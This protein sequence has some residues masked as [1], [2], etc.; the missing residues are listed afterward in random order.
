MLR[1]ERD[2]LPLIDVV[3]LPEAPVRQRTGAA[4]VEA[5]VDEQDENS[6][7]EDNEENQHHAEGDKSKE[8]VGLSRAQPISEAQPAASNDDTEDEPHFSLH[9]QH[10]LRLTRPY[11]SLSAPSTEWRC[12]VCARDEES[13]PDKQCWHC[14]RCSYDVCQQC[15]R[16]ASGAQNQGDEQA[17][18][19]NTHSNAAG[20]LQP[21]KDSTDDGESDDDEDI[22]LV[23]AKE[24][25][26]SAKYAWLP[27]DF[28]VGD[29]GTVR[30][31]SY[32]NNLHPVQHAAMYP[33]VERVVA[34]F[35]PLFER[36]LTSLRNPPQVKV[37]VGSWYDAADD[38]RHEADKAAQRKE[39]GD[40]FDEDENWETWHDSRP[41]H[42]PLV[43]PFEPR[44]S[45]S[46]VVSLRDRRLQ[47]IVKL[48]DIVLTPEQPN[49]AGGVWHVEG[50]RNE[51]IVSSGIAYY[52]QSNIGPSS[53]A[54]R[55]AVNE[56]EY[57]QDDHRG[58]EAIYGL[59]NEEPLVQPLGAVDTG[60][61]RCIALP[62]IYQHRVAPFSLL[63][64]SKPGHRSILV[65]FLV[66][67]SISI[68]STS[69]VPPQQREWIAPE[70]EP[71]VTDA[72]GGIRV[73]SELVHS[74]VDWPMART[75]AEQHRTALMHER[76]YFV[77]ENTNSVFER[78]FS[79]CE[80]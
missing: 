41:I 15:F 56:P 47:L 77:E 74:Y 19:G 36:V 11:V 76:K 31:L 78:E 28:H 14:E 51:C 72:L 29:E 79:L 55:C 9:P 49:Y 21:T 10:P 58:L 69:R 2:E 39:Q 17:A 53:L 54:F 18:E 67:P 8:S 3:V 37:P 45:A 24:Y 73:L 66:D 22:A 43:P 44:A 16:R 12:D 57:E 1:E 23:V 70:Y 35:I 33:L 30:C 42:Q 48:A 75:E 62:N 5:A 46:S 63:D 65:L 34:R 26:T 64:P 32:I 38:E 25:D 13:T 80:H 68:L 50:M 6:E 4:A 40:E 59:R 52:D 60:N 7:D 20:G 71:L 61:G 27:A